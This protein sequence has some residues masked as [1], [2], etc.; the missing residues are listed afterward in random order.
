MRLIELAR[1]IAPEILSKSPEQPDDSLPQAPPRE[2]RRSLSPGLQPEK[3][4]RFSVA[5]VLGSCLLP[6]WLV[7]PN[8][9]RAIAYNALRNLGKYLYGPSDSLTVQR[10]PFGLYLKYHGDLPLYDNER[11][12]LQTVRQHTTIPVPAPLDVVEVT[13][14]DPNDRYSFSNGYMLI[15]RVPGIPLSSCQDILSDQDFE[16]IGYQMKDYLSQLRDIPK[17]VNPGMAICNTLGEACRDAR[18]CGDA[19]VGPFADEAAFSQVLRFSDDPSRRGHRIFFTH[20]DLNPRNILVDRVVR[21]DGRPGWQISGI[22][23]WE[24][25]GYYPEYWDYTKALFEGFRWGKRYT[26]WVTAVFST[27]G[28]YSRELDVE[29]RSWES[30]DGV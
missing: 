29:R 21:R 19:P 5:N 2:Q 10:L 26:N 20:A 30:G 6:L 14:E 16:H 1:K 25:A 4:R 9:V 27:F 22:V 23:D 18:V 8:K 15:T 7:F 28:D 17:T 3:N 11:K 12:A 24:M 13:P